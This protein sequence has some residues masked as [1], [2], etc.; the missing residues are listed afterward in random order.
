MSDHKVGFAKPPKH[1][2]FKPGI[3]G[4]S[5]G[6]P[7]GRVP[8]TQLLEKHLNE[9]TTIM[10]EG[11][12]KTMSRREALIIGHI[13]DALTGGD[14]VR[15]HVI[16]LLLMLDAKMVP[17]TPDAV[18]HKLDEAVIASLLYRYG[19]KAPPN[20]SPSPP[21]KAQVKIKIVNSKNKEAAK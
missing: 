19:V 4:N 2:Q 15:K 5:S 1:T 8:I 3:S 9:K 12:K 14:K 16:D 18:N 11:K 7:K 6:R 21:P 10:V 17:E 20:A 13:N